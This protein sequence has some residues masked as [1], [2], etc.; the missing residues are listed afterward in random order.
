M[1]FIL[2]CMF[3]L[4]ATGAFAAWPISLRVGASCTGDEDRLL[5]HE[6]D[7]TVIY[8]CKDGHVDRKMIDSGS[9]AGASQEESLDAVGFEAL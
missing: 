4:F 3:C 6:R 8:S 7:G 2:G 1:K 5:K 9:A